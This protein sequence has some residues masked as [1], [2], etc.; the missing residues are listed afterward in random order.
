VQ[1]LK[2]VEIIESYY[3]SFYYTVGVNTNG[4]GI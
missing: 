1:E 2:T 4:A 3:Y